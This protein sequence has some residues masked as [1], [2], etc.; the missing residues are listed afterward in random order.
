MKLIWCE[1]SERGDHSS[2]LGGHCNTGT[3]RYTLTAAASFRRLNCSFWMVSFSREKC[4]LLHSIY[5]KP[6]LIVYLQAEEFTQ[7]KTKAHQNL[8]QWF[9]MFLP[10]LL[11]C[12][13]SDM[14]PKI[15][16]CSCKA[17]LAKS[18]NRKWAGYENNRV[19]L[20]KT[21]RLFSC[22]IMLNCILLTQ[23]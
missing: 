22:D 13:I 20:Y 2:C 15:Q 3:S 9:Q 8:D 23:H 19:P 6:L 5:L 4:F 17:N 10:E 7:V 12:H 21:R 14:C 16:N 11:C 1:K 18:T